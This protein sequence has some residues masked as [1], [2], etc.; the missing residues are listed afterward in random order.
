MFPRESRQVSANSAGQVRGEDTSCKTF[1]SHRVNLPK[2]LL[3]FAHVSATGRTAGRREQLSH[4]ISTLV[5]FP[6]HPQLVHIQHFQN[7]Y[8]TISNSWD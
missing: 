8:M 5:S 3:L 7:Q 4:S 6:L 2:F 1:A